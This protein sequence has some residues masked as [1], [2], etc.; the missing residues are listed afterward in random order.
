[1]LDVAN[2]D[3]RGDPDWFKDQIAVT[4]GKNAD[5][6]AERLARA[7]VERHGDELRDD[8]AILVLHRNDS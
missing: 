7:A 6:I 1:V 3:K 2:R 5:E 8:I 4:T